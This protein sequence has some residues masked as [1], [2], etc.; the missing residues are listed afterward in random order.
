MSINSLTNT[1]LRRQA[2]MEGASRVEELE[3][4]A[5]PRL[6]VAP[7]AE[8]LEDNQVNNALDILTKYIP[9]ETVTLY[10]AAV[11]ATPALQALFGSERVEVGPVVYW[12]FALLTPVLMVLVLMSK[13]AASGLPAQPPRWPRWHLVAATVAFLVWALAVPNNPYI[14]SDAA[15]IVAGF[16]AIFISTVLSL[17]DPILSRSSNAP[18]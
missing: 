3:E 17:L 16:G 13:R 15:S 14:N 11:S 4:L 8:S 6:T 1:E 2:A 10:V 18:A 5:G 9:T 7:A 12:L